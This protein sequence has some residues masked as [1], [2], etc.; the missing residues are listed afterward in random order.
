MFVPKYLPV[1]HK[2]SICTYKSHAAC[3]VIWMFDILSLCFGHSFKEIH[4]WEALSKAQ[5]EFR[6]FCRKSHKCYSVCYSYSD[7][8][9]SVS[10]LS[11]LNL[12]L[13][14]WKVSEI[15]AAVGTELILWGLLES[16]SLIFVQMVWYI[17]YSFKC[18]WLWDAIGACIHAQHANI[19]HFWSLRIPSAWKSPSQCSL[20]DTICLRLQQMAQ[21]PQS[22]CLIPLKMFFLYRTSVV[23]LYNKT[24]ITLLLYTVDGC[25]FLHYVAWT[26][27]GW[28]IGIIHPVLS[29]VL[30]FRAK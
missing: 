26:S 24:D 12:H 3:E 5:K 16:N 2:C 8:C 15:T 19:S 28:C 27:R 4:F 18:M 20:R 7:R 14:C 17:W 10:C 13:F 22:P 23:V 9:L 1:W 11:L 29:P 6:C 21:R 25:L 30:L